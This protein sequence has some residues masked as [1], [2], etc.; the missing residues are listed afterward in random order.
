MIYNVFEL[1]DAANI[2]SYFKNVVIS[3]NRQPHGPIPVIRCRQVRECSL[4]NFPVNL[5]KT[6]QC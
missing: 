1:K 2:I 6:N 5:A 4:N 3:N